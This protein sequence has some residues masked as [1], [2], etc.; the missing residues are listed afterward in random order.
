MEVFVRV[1]DRGGFAAAA[2]ELGMSPAMASKHVRAL[3]DRLGAKLLHRTT[4]RRSLT[5][6]GQQYLERCRAIIAEADAADASAEELRA[7][8]RGTLRVTA[9]VSFGA[10]RL[11]PAMLRP[12]YDL[13]ADRLAI[14]RE[15][16]GDRHSIGVQIALIK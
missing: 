5:E 4:R 13:Y 15:H 1:V 3:E 14:Q 6:L 9:P 11:A 7:T 8:P 10:R 16:P 12:L 2:A